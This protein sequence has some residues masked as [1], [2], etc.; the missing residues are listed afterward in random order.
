MSLYLNYHL[1][2]CKTGRRVLVAL[3]MIELTK[4]LFT[5]FRRALIFE[6]PVGQYS[7]PDPVSRV[8]DQVLSLKKMSFHVLALPSIAYFEFYGSN[9]LIFAS[10][11]RNVRFHN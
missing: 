5:P 6:I 11:D 8:S 2:H 9:S 4:V 7:K 10:P 1:L 3:V